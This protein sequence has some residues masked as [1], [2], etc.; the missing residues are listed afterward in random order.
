MFITSCTPEKYKGIE[1]VIEDTGEG[2]KTITVIYEHYSYSFE[3]STFYEL[4]RPERRELD[5]TIPET[6]MDLRAPE[7]KVDLVVPAGSDKVKTRTATFIP[8][9]ISVYIYDP[10]NDGKSATYNATHN[11]NYRLEKEAKFDNFNLIERSPIN[12]SGIK[13]E[14]A[15]WEVGWFNLFPKN[16][17]ESPMEYRWEVIFDYKNQIWWIEGLSSGSAY[18]ERIDAD[19]KHVIETFKILE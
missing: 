16:D 9:S 6:Y 13:G 1:S 17:G 18:R 4:R 2:Y 5:W 10:T 19:F 15:E 7:A 8:A 11:L 14:Y 3:Y 12:L